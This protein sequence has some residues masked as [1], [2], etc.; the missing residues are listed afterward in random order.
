M[1]FTEHFP[2]TTHAHFDS[3]VHV[4]VYITSCN[5]S[6]LMVVYGGGAC[7]IFSL[8]PAPAL[9]FFHLLLWLLFI[10]LHSPVIFG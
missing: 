9:F 4:F 5:V 8:Q 3:Y 7:K 1:I 10:F 2:Y 6:V